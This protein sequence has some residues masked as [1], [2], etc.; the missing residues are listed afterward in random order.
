MKIAHSHV[1]SVSV[2]DNNTGK[3]E[4]IP[5]DYFFSTM[6]IKHLMRMIEPHPPEEVLK[7]SDGLVYRDFM[8]VGLL[9]KQL[10]VRDG[11]KLQAS[12]P[13]NWIYVQEGD[14]KVGRIQVFNNWSPYMVADPE[15]TVWVG[16]EYFVNEGD[17]LWKLS[18]KEMIELGKQELEKI[19]FIV[20]EDVLDGCVLRMP[21]TYPAYFG[22]Y[23]EIDKLRDWTL[24]VPNMFLVGRNGL[25]RYNNQD[26]SMLTAM[27]AVD[28]IVE[29]QTDN[30]NIWEVNAERTYHE[31]KH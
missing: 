17:V 16:L 28:N 9:L 3:N 22:T 26:H 27:T 15:N 31:E 24:K 18:D 14:V 12:I 20:K 19:G 5:C 29:G 8:T 30:R 25:H 10:R 4:E 11:K 6:S 7:I 23:D 13:D 2:W 1:V 21:K